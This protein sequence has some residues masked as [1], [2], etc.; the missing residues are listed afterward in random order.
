MRRRRRVS[1]RK[2]VLSI[3]TAAESRGTE[4]IWEIWQWLT[5]N[6]AFETRWASGC[7]AESV[8]HVLCVCDFGPFGLVA[9]YEAHNKV[10]KGIV[11]NIHLLF[12][13]DSTNRFHFYI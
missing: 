11:F 4:I 5:N 9:T 3:L 1:I 8:P 13:K 10:S 7:E 6:L 12:H 2:G